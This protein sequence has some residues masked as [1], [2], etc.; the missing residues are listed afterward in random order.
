MHG[1]NLFDLAALVVVLAA[2][3]G[4]CNHRYLRLPFTIGMTISGLAASGVVLLADALAPGL[5]IGA[6]VERLFTEDIDFAE[7]LMHGMLSFLL[8]AGALHVDMEDLLEVK[9]RSE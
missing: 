7:S 9:R 4:W 2:V 5:G 8:F 6:A 1:P 3:F